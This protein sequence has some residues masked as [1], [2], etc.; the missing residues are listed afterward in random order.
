MLYKQFS[1]KMDLKFFK[2]HSEKRY[3][4]FPRIIV[5]ELNFNRHEKLVEYISFLKHELHKRDKAND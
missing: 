4:M 1:S 5:G 3:Y 2:N